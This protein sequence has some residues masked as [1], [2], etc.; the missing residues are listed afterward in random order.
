MGAYYD[1]VY[2]DVVSPSPL[3]LKLAYDFA[4]SGRLLFASDHPW[5]RIEVLSQL[6]DELNIPAEE[7]DRVFGGNACALLGIGG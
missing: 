5:V 1:R 2:L 7:K 6:V 3:A 4:G